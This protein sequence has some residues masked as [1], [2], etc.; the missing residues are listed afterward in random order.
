VSHPED[1]KDPDLIGKNIVSSI[2]YNASLCRMGNYGAVVATRNH[3]TVVPRQSHA[4]EKTGITRED[5]SNHY[6]SGVDEDAGMM[7]MGCQN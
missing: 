5:T 4:S 1:S 2:F 7:G 6:F 3:I